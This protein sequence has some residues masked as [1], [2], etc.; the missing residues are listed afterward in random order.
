MA[1]FLAESACSDG[2]E[3]EAARTQLE[4]KYNALLNEYAYAL[5]FDASVINDPQDPM[6]GEHLVLE[7]GLS[8][9]SD[10]AMRV[11]EFLP[12]LVLKGRTLEKVPLFRP[13]VIRRRSS[14]FFSVRFDFPP[15]EAGDMELCAFMGYGPPDGPALR[16]Q[17]IEGR[18]TFKF[19]LGNMVS[20]S[21]LQMSD[22]PGTYQKIHPRRNEGSLIPELGD[23]V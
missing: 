11:E 19:V 14:A 18:I 16:V 22:T 7:M 15:D 10:R 3:A 9:G 6:T 5:H 20:D 13:V 23:T 17:T 21:Q 4:A 12:I 8:N 1:V 2:W